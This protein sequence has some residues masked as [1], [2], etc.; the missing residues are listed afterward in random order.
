MA[1][2]GEQPEPETQHAI[3]LEL[4]TIC[5]NSQFQSSQRNCEFLRYVVTATLAGRATE[6]KER[7][8]GAELYGRPVSYDTGSD[9][10]VRVR[11]N[12]VRKRLAQYYEQHAPR[13]GWRIHLPSR[14]YV[15]QFLPEARP[16][17][18]EPSLTRG[19][20]A[21]AEDSVA[22]RRI[23]TLTQM[24]MPTLIALFLCAATFR[25]Q[26]FSGTPY[27]DFWETLLGNHSAITLVLDADSHDPH[28]V[29]VNDLHT[30][31]PLLQMAANFHAEAKVQSS[32]EVP[33][34][35]ASV[36]RIY[37]THHMPLGEPPG[38][39]ADAAAAYVTVVPGSQP[40]IWICSS[41]PA[42][43]ELAIRSIS[44]AD[45]FPHAL[46]MALRRN[47]PS[48]IRMAERQPVRVE[49]AIA[50]GVLWRR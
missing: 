29:T 14:T 25:W 34:D 23:L 10:V 19:T 48:R 5:G 9:A 32:A 1:T 27:L 30:V 40:Q 45:A 33:Q 4:E 24:M 42:A 3:E 49:T 44:G 50:P 2:P 39:A 15:P 21:L 26:I 37:V 11:A 6:I 46:E 12:D 28:A 38:L 41:D 16:I 47:M 20:A 43:L 35:R 31:T 7:I 36:V 18:V 17:A 8:L 13:A 22:P